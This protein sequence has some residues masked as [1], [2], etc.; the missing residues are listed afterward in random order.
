MDAPRRWS[1]AWLI[2]GVA[3]LGLAVFYF[4]WGLPRLAPGANKGLG[5]IWL[6]TGSLCLLRARPRRQGGR[7]GNGS[8]S[9]A[10]PG[11]APD[12]GRKAGPGR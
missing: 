7:D 12:R 10:E 1:I 3:L 8:S 11:A 2:A 4:G 9:R 6:A 5:L